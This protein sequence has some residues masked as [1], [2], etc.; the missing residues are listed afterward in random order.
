MEIERKWL[1]Q[2]W[3][4]NMEPCKII[5]MRQGYITTRPTVRIRSEESNGKTE[6]ILCF[7]GKATPDGLAREEIESPI[8]GELFARLERFLGKPLIEKQ[9]RR[10]DLPGGLVLEVNQVDAGQPGEFFYA[11]I[12]FDTQEQAKA[13]VPGDLTEYLKQEVTG[14]PGQNMAAYWRSTRGEFEADQPKE[15]GFS[16]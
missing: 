16:L 6:Y 12:E 7:K 15:G 4:N 2:G 13:F 14:I 10:Y 3:P 1:V 8:D 5:T 11:E 9:Q